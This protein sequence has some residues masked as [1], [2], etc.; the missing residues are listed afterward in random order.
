[1][2]RL[3]LALTLMAAAA[4]TAFADDH[5]TAVAE[6]RDHKP[7][8]ELG[9][10]GG[11][12]GIG[13]EL[14]CP[15]NDRIRVRA[16]YTYMPHFNYNMT[17]TAQ[18]GAGNQMSSDGTHTRF[19]RIAELLEEFVG[20]PIDDKVE[21]VGTPYMSQAKLLLDVAPFSNKAW[22]F[23]AGFYLGKSRVAQALNRSHEISSLFA[24]NLYNRMVERHGEITHG[25]SLPPEYLEQLLTYGM[26][27]FHT[28]NYTHDVMAYDEE[29]DEWYT[30]HSKG[31]AYLMGVSS[32]NTVYADAFV[33]KF[34]PYFGFGYN[35]SVGRERRWHV[36]VDAGALFWGGAPRLV[37]HSGTDL[38]YDVEDISGDVGRYVDI[39]RHFKAFPV[40]E[41]HIS[42][43]IF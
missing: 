16:G 27:G 35:S 5:N 28:G 23:T 36:G 43:R 33:N 4:T 14:A 17:F 39:A 42:Y 38:M 40:L 15:V 7:H 2:N 11:T 21:M 25:I 19:Q 41:L 34:R 13:L 6:R 12:T 32:D 30:D 26:A 29:W 20:Q 9:V 24:I 3:L 22:H 10:T 31:D 18:V 37:D 1:M 8:L